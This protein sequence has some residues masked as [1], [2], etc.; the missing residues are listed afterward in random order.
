MGKRLDAGDTIDVATHFLHRLQA[1]GWG[2]LDLEHHIEYVPTRPGGRK[3][4]VEATV[5]IRLTPAREHQ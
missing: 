2:V 5:T 4:P 1:E 3:L